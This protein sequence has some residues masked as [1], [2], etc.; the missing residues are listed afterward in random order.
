MNPT[1]S[2]E[3]LAQEQD[4]TTFCPYEWLKEAGSDAPFLYASYAGPLLLPAVACYSL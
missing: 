1:S 3:S 2:V 4:N